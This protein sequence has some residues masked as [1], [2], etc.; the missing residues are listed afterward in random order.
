MIN[1]ITTITIIILI[2]IIAVVIIIITF[3]VVNGTFLKWLKYT[4]AETIP[5]IQIHV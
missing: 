4:L 3:N 2:I 1:I 5:I